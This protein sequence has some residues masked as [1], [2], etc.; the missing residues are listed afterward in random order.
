MLI[1]LLD[2]ADAPGRDLEPELKCG[3][4]EGL[5]GDPQDAD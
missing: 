3:R 4:G 1:D 5:M 2:A